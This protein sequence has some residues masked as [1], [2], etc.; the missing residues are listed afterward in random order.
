MCAG[1]TT[2]TRDPSI[3]WEVASGALR[4][5]GWL[6]AELE[7]PDQLRQPRELRGGRTW[8]ANPVAVW[9][10]KAQSTDYRDESPPSRE[11]PK[12]PSNLND[13]NMVSYGVVNFGILTNDGC[14]SGEGCGDGNMCVTTTAT[15]PAPTTTTTTTPAPATTPAPTTPEPPPPEPSSPWEVASGPCEI[16]DGCLLSSNF[17]ANYGSREKC[18]VTVADASWGSSTLDVQS[19]D[20]EFRYDK[21]TI[22]GKSYSGNVVKAAIPDG[23]RPSGTITW[24]SDGSVVKSGFKLCKA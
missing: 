16:K 15:T 4:D 5:Q 19:F 24:R 3:P 20:T 12:W 9:Q 22:N 21:L 8:Q 1:A 10:G 11:Y 18:V 17:P 2:T 7:L 23:L 13:H 14:G 6:P